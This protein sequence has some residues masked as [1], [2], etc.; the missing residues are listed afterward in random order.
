MFEQSCKDIGFRKFLRTRDLA[1]LWPAEFGPLEPCFVTLFL[2]VLRILHVVLY[3]PD[4]AVV[5]NMHFQKEPR[6]V[7]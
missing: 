7:G 2:F 4:T 3:P 6:G 5:K 1:T